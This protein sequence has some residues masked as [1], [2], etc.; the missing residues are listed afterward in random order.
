MVLIPFPPPSEPCV[1]ISR[2]RLSGSQLAKCK[3]D[4]LVGQIAH[5]PLAWFTLRRRKQSPF[6]AS[7]KHRYFNPHT[8]MVWSLLQLTT[9]RPSPDT[10]RS[11]TW[12]SW[13][14]SAPAISAV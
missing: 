12:S 1:R 14:S 2:T 10:A 3:T 4:T 9:Q 13:P 6:P 7:G 8:R 5:H 11:V